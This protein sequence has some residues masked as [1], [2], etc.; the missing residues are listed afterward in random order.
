MTQAFSLDMSVVL[1]GNKK[2]QGKNV[3]LEYLKKKQRI[4]D[5]ALEYVQKTLSEEK[6]ITVLS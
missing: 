4:W 5:E 2:S 3:D 6:S 1:F